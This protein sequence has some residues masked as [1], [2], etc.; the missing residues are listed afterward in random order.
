MFFFKKVILLSFLMLIVIPLLDTSNDNAQDT[1][2]LI[3]TA[4][5]NLRY[6]Y[7]SNSSILLLLLL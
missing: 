7:E 4:L 6:C 5:D 2:L 3:E 1:A